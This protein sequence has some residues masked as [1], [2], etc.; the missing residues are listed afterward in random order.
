MSVEL[1]TLGDRND[2]SRKS[3]KGEIIIGSL[4]SFSF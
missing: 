2:D 3:S 4:Y 1:D